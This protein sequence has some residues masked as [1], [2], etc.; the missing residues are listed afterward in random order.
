MKIFVVAFKHIHKTSNSFFYFFR[1]K[2]F[3]FVRIKIYLIKYI[4]YFLFYLFT[5]VLNILLFL[6]AYRK[7]LRFTLLT[8]FSLFF[9][10]DLSFFYLTNIKYWALIYKANIFNNNIL[11]KLF[12]YNIQYLRLEFFKLDQLIE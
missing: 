6:K 4:E 10:L 12:P 8:I 5:F 7:W 2:L 3:V 1:I 9:L 11:I